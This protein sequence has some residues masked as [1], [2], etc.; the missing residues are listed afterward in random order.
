MKTY[1]LPEADKEAYLRSHDPRLIVGKQQQQ[2]QLQEHPDIKRFLEWKAMHEVRGSLLHSAPGA[3]TSTARLMRGV[4]RSCSGSDGNRQASYR[5]PVLA[6]S[7][8]F[9]QA[10]HPDAGAAFAGKIPHDFIPQMT[11][12]TKQE[13]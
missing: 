5:C 9:P 4:S 3:C 13:L 2:E 7:A 1:N 11:K 12:P 10:G 8:L 6:L